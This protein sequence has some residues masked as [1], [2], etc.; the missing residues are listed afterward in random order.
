MF[1]GLGFSFAKRLRNFCGTERKILLP[2]RKFLGE[3]KH[4]AQF[5]RNE[6]QKICFRCV[7]FLGEKTAFC[8][9]FCNTAFAQ[10]CF[11]Q[12][13]VRNVHMLCYYAMFI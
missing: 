12:L 8:A 13:R 4:F 5:L 9:K 2:L 7:T 6:T 11:V 10:L 3:K 1:S